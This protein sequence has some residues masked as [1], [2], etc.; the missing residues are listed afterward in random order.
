MFV[1]FLHTFKDDRTVSAGL[2]NFFHWDTE[3]P[4]QNCHDAVHT[5]SGLAPAHARTRASFDAIE[6]ACTKRPMNG[7]ENFAFCDRIAAADDR[8][9]SWI[10]LY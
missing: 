3:F 8:S 6:T 2:G 7:I 4:V 5:E 9:L 10:L 1:P